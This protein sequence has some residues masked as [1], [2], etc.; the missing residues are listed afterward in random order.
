MRK[1]LTK[2]EVRGFRCLRVIRVTN[3]KNTPLRNG[4]LN[5]GVAITVR[6]LLLCF[7]YVDL[8]IP[9]Q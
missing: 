6:Y 4:R 1:K 7:I 3:F 5:F 9:A 2:L 8:P